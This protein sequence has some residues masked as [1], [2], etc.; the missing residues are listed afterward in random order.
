MTAL[1]Y[2]EIDQGS[3]EGIHNGKSKVAQNEKKYV[4]FL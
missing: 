4:F 1:F 2:V 3:A